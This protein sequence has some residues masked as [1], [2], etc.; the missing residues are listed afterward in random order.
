MEQTPKD[1]AIVQLTDAIHYALKHL[2]LDEF[3]KELADAIPHD[4]LRIIHGKIV[5]L[6]LD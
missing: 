4:E 5:P 3:T 6:I 1:I 2:S